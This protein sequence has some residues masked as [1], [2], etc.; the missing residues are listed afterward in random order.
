MMALPSLNAIRVF[1]A[2]ARQG[3]FKAAA[4]EL[5][6]SPS[7]VS[8][9]IRALELSLGVVLFERGFREVRLTEKSTHYAR[10]LTEA[11]RT[12]V[13][14]TEEIGAYGPQRRRSKRR[15]TLSVNS[16]FMNL[17][18]A[19]RLAGF[20]RLCPE[21]DVEVSVHDDQ[22]RG[23]NPRADLKVLFTPDDSVDPSSTLLVPLVIIPVCA[24]ALAKGRNGL[25][26]PA[27][28]ARHRLLH[29]NTTLWWEEWIE[30]Q[31]V[32][33]IDPKAGAIFHDPSLAIREAVNG[34]GV[35]L[36]DN[37]MAEDLLR[38]GHLVDPF[39]IR[40]PIPNCY[41]LAVRS[42]ALAQNGVHR[43]R[44]WLVAEIEKHKRVMKL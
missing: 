19:D 6:L 43:F 11:L 27:D 39:G 42:G 2:A 38:Q 16:V 8:R 10:R 3:S 26:R 13:D 5:S 22:E 36:A 18:L 34:G 31:G 24:P 44:E 21:Y 7:A 33:G 40:R 15:I 28:L 4:E 32:R 14:A 25:R 1:E 17:W 29:E 20:R 41:A 30:A 12:I 23:G 9:H 37:I 35:A